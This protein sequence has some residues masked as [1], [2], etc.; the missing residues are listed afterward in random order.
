MNICKCSNTLIIGENK[1]DLLFYDLN[2][3]QFDG[4]IPNFP[5]KNNNCLIN[6]DN[7]KFIYAGD[8]GNIYLIQIGTLLIKQY[9]V[10]SSIQTINLL[11]NGLIILIGNKKNTNLIK[12]INI[13]DQ[14]EI[15]LGKTNSQDIFTSIV[16]LEEENYIAASSKCG[17]IEIFYLK[18]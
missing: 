8:N 1:S 14:K 3:E 13:Y 2:K 9:T 11:N 17:L 15:D 4:K 6:I 5:C 10:K 18:E 12:I 16:Q 7:N